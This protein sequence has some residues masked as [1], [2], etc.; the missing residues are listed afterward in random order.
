MNTALL[1]KYPAPKIIVEC[2]TCGMRAKYDKLEMLEAGGDRPLT[3]LLDEIARRKG[4]TRMDR[5]DIRNLC[6]ARYANLLAGN[7][8]S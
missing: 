8:S 1:S 6:R 5:F 4:C 7:T 2:E 3:H